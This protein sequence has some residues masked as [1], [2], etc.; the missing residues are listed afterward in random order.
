MPTTPSTQMEIDTGQV[1][2]RNEILSENDH[3]EE[4]EV[5]KSDKSSDNNTSVKKA[6]C[7]GILLEMEFRR[8]QGPEDANEV[9]QMTI[10]HTTQLINK[11]LE[12]KSIEG[13]NTHDGIM[14]KDDFNDVDKW[15]HPIKIVERKDSIS[16][17]MILQACTS[18]STHK[19]CQDVKEVCQN[20]K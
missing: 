12:S 20:T 4:Q 19:L 5:N 2:E 14:K 13:I 8:E 18:L 7:K 6:R 11:W 1:D 15:V 9:D 10:E 16:I 3:V 17:N